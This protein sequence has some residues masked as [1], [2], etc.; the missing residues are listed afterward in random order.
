MGE[1][2]HSFAPKVGYILGYIFRQSPVIPLEN[3]GWLFRNIEDSQ[4]LTGIRENPDLYGVQGVAG[5]NPAVPTRI[6]EGPASTCDAGP[7]FLRPS[8]GRLDMRWRMSS[9][10]EHRLP[11]FRLGV[12]VLLPAPGSSGARTPPPARAGGVS[13]DS[14]RISSRSLSGSALRPVSELR[15]PVS[16]EGRKERL[17][18]SCQ[19]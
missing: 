9:A 13:A 12:L 4:Q 19:R 5:S 18:S 17:R 3:S 15:R 14:A 2:P 7:L 8:V 1:R 10:A 11:R 16:V 6:S